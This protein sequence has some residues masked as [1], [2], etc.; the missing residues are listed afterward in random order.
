MRELRAVAGTDPILLTL[1]PERP[2]AI[3]ATAEAVRL[4]IKVSLGHTNAPAETLLKAI[5]AGATGF[6]HLGNGCPRQLD[7]H[8]NILWRVF[9]IA[10]KQSHSGDRPLTISLIPDKIH[11]SPPLFRLAHQVLPHESIFYIT[12]AMA[13]AGA[14]PGRYTLG[15]LNLEV[16]EDQ[17]VRLPG[18]PNFAGSALRPID[19]VIRAVEMLGAPW[20]EVWR[21][22]S[23]LPA[24]FM[25]LD[26]AFKI[27]N[28]A[29]ISQIKTM[30]EN[31]VSAK[32]IA[33]F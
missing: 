26:L 20:Q 9:E 29:K 28:R 4:G 15:R 25:G 14:P 30:G 33:C 18:Q 1:A 27:G 24:K 11:V 21:R 23:E 8:D 22:Y 13:A 7:R 10:G 31:I 16:G 12:D 3:E 32:V 6:T 19:G 17:V 5:A 2:G